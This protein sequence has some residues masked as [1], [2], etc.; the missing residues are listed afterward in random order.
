MPGSP[1]PLPETEEIPLA[2]TL[3]RCAPWAEIGRK[4]GRHPSAVMREVTASGGRSRYRPAIAERR[5]G[6]GRCR[7]RPRRLET[8]GVL[9]DRVVSELRLGRSPVA[10][11]ADLV[12]QGGCERV[13][14]ETIYTAIYAGALGVKAADVDVV[15]PV[16]RPNALVY[17]TSLPVPLSSMIG[18]SWQGPTGSSIHRSTTRPERSSLLEVSDN[19]L[20][21]VI[22]IRH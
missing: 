20:Q 18:A 5:A 12:A 19:G 6:T 4:V 7:P 13:C 21:M 22:D 10:I 15:R 2:L 17:P 8:P 1:L 16:T 9:R 14:T 11:W 3:N